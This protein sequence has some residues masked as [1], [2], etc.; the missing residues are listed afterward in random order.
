VARAKREVGAACQCLIV[1]S[2][3]FCR[4][5]DWCQLNGIML[6]KVRSASLLSLWCP[7]PQ[8]ADPSP[9][10]TIGRMSPTRLTYKQT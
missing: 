10:A 1:V 2:E 4:K 3:K 8:G 7:V 6:H 9:S 5:I